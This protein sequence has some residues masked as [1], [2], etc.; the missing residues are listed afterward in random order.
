MSREGDM[1]F[2]NVCITSVQDVVKNIRI[3]NGGAKVMPVKSWKK[4]LKNAI[5]NGGF[6]IGLAD[7]IDIM[8]NSEVCLDLPDSDK[9]KPYGLFFNS[10]IKGKLGLVKF[11]VE[12]EFVDP[13]F[14]DS[15]GWTALDYAQK[16]RRYEVIH[17]L[18]QASSA[19]K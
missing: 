10:A 4:E 6:E 18:I 1:D 12:N 5:E 11:F 15:K 3:P 14:K 8:E 9:N 16:T 2:F 13:D 19:R 7:V 17:Y